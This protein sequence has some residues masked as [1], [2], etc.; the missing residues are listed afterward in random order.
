[1]GVFGGPEGEKRQSGQVL[2]PGLIPFFWKLGRKYFNRSS[3]ACLNHPSPLCGV[4]SFGN[5]KKMCGSPHI[6]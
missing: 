1:M 5:L 4:F 3:D 2:A 6:P